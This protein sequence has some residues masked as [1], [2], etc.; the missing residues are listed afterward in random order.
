[1]NNLVFVKFG[2]S[3]LTDKNAP[4][5]LATAA[6]ADVAR[7]L[8]AV[9]YEQPELAVVVGHGGGSF[10]HYWAE[11]YRTHEGITGP[12]SWWGVA[13]VADAMA[14]LNRAV[15][16]A[17]L[18]A[19]LPALGVQPLASAYA[20]NARITTIG[21]TQIAALLAGS[22]IPVIYGD[23]LLDS[24]RGC[25]I[26]STETL[27]AALVPHLQPRRIILVGEEAVYDADPR[28][29]RA[30]QPIPYI[31]ATNYPGVLARLSGSHG[32]DVTGGMRSKVEAMWALA[33][34][35]PRLEI[36]ICGPGSLAAALEGGKLPN[37]TLI[38][39]TSP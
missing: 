13:R 29:H 22:I 26:A 36:A 2:G 23:V 25:S 6:L 10:G 1:M 9:R 20:S 4:E 28:Q 30:A 7:T 19:E 14:R 33:M 5:S 35:M 15:V 39:G 27:F 12:E 24:V 38:R 16:S 37:G 8:A 31:D 11:M 18:Q 3:I 21:H 32:V 34:S 17:L